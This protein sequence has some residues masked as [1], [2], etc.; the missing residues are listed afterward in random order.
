MEGYPGLVVH[1]PLQAVALAE[2]CR[3][4][5]PER[6]VRSFRFRALRPAFDGH[7]LHIAGRLDDDGTEVS[8]AAIDHH[9]EI[10]MR[11]DATLDPNPT[12][13]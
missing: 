2:L 1:G 8:L 3:R 11:A 13:P 9:G 5:L 12:S 7:P 10:T 4:H 6:V